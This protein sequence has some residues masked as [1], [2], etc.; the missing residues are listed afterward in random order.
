MKQRDALP[1][2]SFTNYYGAQ[3]TTVLLNAADSVKYAVKTA[4][5]VKQ[6]KRIETLLERESIGDLAAAEGRRIHPRDS[7]VVSFKV[8]RSN[9]WQPRFRIYTGKWIRFSSRRRNID[10]AVIL[11]DCK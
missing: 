2:F 5:I 11:I 8:S 3:S 1:I 6:H 4:S 7:E 10:D 9:Y